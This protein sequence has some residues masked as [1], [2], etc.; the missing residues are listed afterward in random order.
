MI[1][2]LMGYIPT[3]VLYVAVK[4]GI[5]D[6]ISDDGASASDLA[7]KLG[8]HSGAL[9]RVLRTLAGIGVLHQDENDLFFLTPLG[10]TLRKD[11]PQ[12]VRDYAI[13]SHEFVYDGFRNI[14]ESVRTGKPVIDD[15]FAYLRSN[16]ELETIFHAGIGNRGRIETKAILQAFDF[17][18]CRQVVDV[19]G[20][21]GAFLSSLLAS[22]EQVSGVL[23]DQESAIRAAESGRGGSLP[24]CRLVAG[25]FFDRVPSGGDIYILK[26][27]LFDWTD[28]EAIKILENCRKASDGEA[29]LLIIEPLIGPP[30]EQTPAHLYDMTFLVLLTGRVRTQ[31]EYTAL[32]SQ[33][34]FRLDRII[35]TDSDVSILEA[36]TN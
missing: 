33:A 25:D 17:S 1:R 34:G 6:H 19:G 9:Y 32:L 31:D 5:A 23:F 14:T 22:H 36:F 20:G 30:N 3:R 21:N 26:R 27:V 8:V 11:S 2:L 13:Y 24:R 16:P 10:K 28:N 15:F 18:K 12:S 35:P 7:Q 4:L 29:R